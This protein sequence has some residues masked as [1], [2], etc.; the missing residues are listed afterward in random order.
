MEKF[1]ALPYEKQE[2]IVDAAMKVFA[3]AGYKKTYVSEIAKESGISKAMVFFYFGSKKSLY[4]YLMEISFSAVAA[5]FSKLL[6]HNVTDFFDRILQMT[7]VKLSVMQEH[8]DILA[9]LTSMYF[10]RDEE[11]IEEIKAALKTGEAIRNDMTLTDI[12]REK[13]KDGIDPQ[14]VVNILVKY[15]EGY[16]SSIPKGQ[17]FELDAVNEEFYRCVK[18]MKN[19]FYREE[20]L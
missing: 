13:F 19:N 12:D 15:A 3:S 5:A 10:E 20:Y 7:Q 6:N 11:V 16:I 18:L 8:P 1:L 9:F 2:T 17:P 4:L 14:L